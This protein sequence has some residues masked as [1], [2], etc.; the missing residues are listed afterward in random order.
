MA[1]IMTVKEHIGRYEDVKVGHML[2]MWRVGWRERWAVRGRQGGVGRCP[3][4]AVHIALVHKAASG[5]GVRVS[6]V[7]VQQ[8]CG[9]AR[10]A[11]CSCKAAP[12]CL[13]TLERSGLRDTCH[14]QPQPHPEP[15]PKLKPK[16][17][18]TSP[19]PRWY[20]WA[21]ATTSSTPGCGWQRAS[22]W[23]L[24]APAPR[25]RPPEAAWRSLPAACWAGLHQC[26]PLFPVQRGLPCASTLCPVLPPPGPPSQPPT[27]PLGRL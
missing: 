10:S 27:H 22:R 3:L 13:L 19:R 18:P 21:T 4:P 26:S 6:P 11:A 25:V 2:C 20:M 24:C 1:D 5:Q 17:K 16:L 15:K 9:T 7:L 12:P 14:C 23:T 8:R